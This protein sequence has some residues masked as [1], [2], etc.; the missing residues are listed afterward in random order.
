MT[1]ATNT[2]VLTTPG[3]LLKAVHHRLGDSL[4][5]W[6]PEEI[7]AACMLEV[8]C[9]AVVDGGQAV[10]LERCETGPRGDVLV[11]VR[12]EDPDLEGP[13]DVAVFRVRPSTGEWSVNRRAIPMPSPARSQ[14]SAS[15]ERLT[16][17]GDV[18]RVDAA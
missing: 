15:R 4:S 16:Q 1:A 13:A 3:A 14:D 8:F 11:S 7:H 5:G 2:S 9:E 18:S 12:R 17:R 10:R 6:R